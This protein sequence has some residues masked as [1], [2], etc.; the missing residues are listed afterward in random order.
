MI[1]LGLAFHPSFQFSLLQNRSPITSWVPATVTF[2]GPELNIETNHAHRWWTVTC[3]LYMSCVHTYSSHIYIL[4]HIL[5]IYS[6]I[7][8]QFHTHIA[9]KIQSTLL[10][11]L[12]GLPAIT[13]CLRQYHRAEPPQHHLYLGQHCRTNTC[14]AQRCPGFPWQHRGSVLVNL[15]E[16]FNRARRLQ[17]SSFSELDTYPCGFRIFFRSLGWR[18]HEIHHHDMVIHGVGTAHSSN[19]SWMRNPYLLFTV[20]GHLQKTLG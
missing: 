17:P 8:T 19:S 5:Y 1:C 3:C 9:Y 18:I 10:P 14:G 6:T 7:F 2:P 4:T 16:V 20:L 12:P 13:C 11:T 15:W